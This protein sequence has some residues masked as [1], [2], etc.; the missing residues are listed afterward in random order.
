MTTTALLLSVLLLAAVLL[1]SVQGRRRKG[2]RTPPTAQEELLARECCTFDYATCDT[3]WCA[4]S[5]EQCHQCEHTS[6]GVLDPDAQ[7]TARWKSCGGNDDE[8]CADLV[9][10][11][12]EDYDGCGIVGV[13]GMESEPEAAPC[14]TFD[15]AT[16]DN[17]W[18]GQSQENCKACDNSYWRVVDTEAVRT[19]R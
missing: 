19:P 1:V 8:C 15:F 5:E 12:Y 14:C 10:L 2:G 13:D 3:G 6:W 9:C 17:D 16:C 18:C 11:Q 7:C 4:A